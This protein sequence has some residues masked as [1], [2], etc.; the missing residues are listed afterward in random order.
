MDGRS[1]H[2]TCASRIK[3]EVKRT[4]ENRIAEAKAKALPRGARP[5]LLGHA[6]EAQHGHKVG[7][8]AGLMAIVH[9][10]RLDGRRESEPCFRAGVCTTL[11]EFGPR[12]WKLQEELT[13]VYAARLVREGGRLDG[14]KISQLLFF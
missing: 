4:S 8:Y 12:M 9:R 13:R 1:V 3:A 2:P 6:A 11:G 5:A 14:F 7:C 10:Q